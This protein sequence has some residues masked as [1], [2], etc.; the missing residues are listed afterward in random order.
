MRLLTWL[1]SNPV[2]WKR[3]PAWFY[4]KE[5]PPGTDGQ[6]GGW[7]HGWIENPL[8]IRRCFIL[9]LPFIPSR[10]IMIHAKKRLL[11]EKRIDC[12]SVPLSEHL[13]LAVMTIPNLLFNIMNCILTQRYIYSSIGTSIDL[14]IHPLIR[15]VVRSLVCNNLYHHSIL[16]DQC[17]G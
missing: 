17:R 2:P 16:L 3:D 7:T 11:P 13:S 9:T 5:K 8:E 10:F 4:A 15:L 12:Y 14:S 6:T 1:T